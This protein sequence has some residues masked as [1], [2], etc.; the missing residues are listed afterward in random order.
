MGEAEM[1]RL[2]YDQFQ[3]TVTT[4]QVAAQMT[5]T[6]DEKALY[7]A[8]QVGAE[9]GATCY[10][11]VDCVNVPGTSE[12]STRNILRKSAMYS[13]TNKWFGLA[14]QNLEA[15]IDDPKVVKACCN[16][17][18]GGPGDWNTCANPACTEA[19]KHTSSSTTFQPSQE[20]IPAGQCVC[21]LLRDAAGQA[22]RVQAERRA[23]IQ[24]L[25]YM[26]YN[27]KNTTAVQNFCNGFTWCQSV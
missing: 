27:L 19:T 1:M 15:L 22:Q 25:K 11:D 16:P 21:T 5:Y 6:A 4:A 14:Q 9:F 18:Q 23:A 12:A 10:G 13:T 26:S 17:L 2:A 7:Q 3:H 8:H 20:S 24:L